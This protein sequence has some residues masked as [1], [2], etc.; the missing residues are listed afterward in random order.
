MN[1]AQLALRN[2]F[3]NKR[4]TVLT[5]LAMIVAT[6]A[7]LVLGGFVSSIQYGMQT[8]IVRQQGHLHIYPKGYLDYGA[9]RPGEM[10]IANYEQ[11]I[12]KLNRAPFANEIRVLTPMLDLVGIAGNYDADSSKTFVG[13]GLLPADYNKM[14]TWNGFDLETS[15]KPVELD[16]GASEQA[17]IG[18][19]L[20]RM[21]DLCQQ[22]QVANCPPAP[23]KRSLTVADAKTDNDI[24]ALQETMGAELAQAKPK[25]A[26]MPRLDLLAASARGAPNIVSVFVRKAREQAQ[27]N[28]DDGLVLMHLSQ[29]QKLGQGGAKNATRIVI[30][31][32]SS[33]RMQAVKK[34][35]EAWLAA[36]GS[37]LEVRTFSEFSPLFD[38]VLR[39]FG[40]I[41]LFV[42]VVIGLVTVFLVVNTMTMSVMERIR[43]IGT[44][45]ALGLRRG[46]IRK[47]FMFEGGWLGI[48]GA[49]IGVLV[50]VLIVMLINHSGLQ[51]TPPNNVSSQPLIL[52]LFH[53]PAFIAGCWFAMVS[54]G[55]LASWLPAN[56][57]ARLQVVDALRHV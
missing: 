39:M 2:T 4:R 28:L 1:T 23:K 52:L 55:I 48:A 31:L 54:I 56:R 24:A 21:L 36:Q 5:L 17:I 43:E 6:S 30:Q 38:R 20:A 8:N 32:N 33:N 16:A 22:L 29:A 51:W 44:I 25:E 12:E 37:D 50:A 57:A 45:R 42:F 3:R 47:Q 13:V 27:K 10:V 26:G 14:L 34:E 46:G 7:L 19:G 41:F 35:L 40:A 11:L 49:S 15:E 18:T 9:S 53:N